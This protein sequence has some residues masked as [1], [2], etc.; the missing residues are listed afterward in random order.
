MSAFRRCIV[1]LQNV[2]RTPSL[3]L[4]L[5]VGLVAF[6]AANAYSRFQIE[7]D[8]AN[9]ERLNQKVSIYKQVV[10]TNPDLNLI[11]LYHRGYTE[12][13]LHRTP[14]GGFYRFNPSQSLVYNPNIASE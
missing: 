12:Q 11:D 10:G 9:I 4:V 1:L 5:A 7:Q 3:S 8:K 6:L 2:R 14:F 13:R